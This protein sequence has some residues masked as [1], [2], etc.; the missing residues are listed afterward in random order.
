M[1]SK[2]FYVG[3]N[4]QNSSESMSKLDW[5]FGK[6]QQRPEHFIY[7][8]MFWS[9]QV[10]VYHSFQSFEGQ[11]GDIDRSR[12]HFGS[13]NGHVDVTASFRQTGHT[14]DRTLSILV[15]RRRRQL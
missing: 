3:S 6:K 1:S 4:A 15:G 13:R 9:R 14:F 11:T 10:L 7:G 2:R 12:M 8:S 5:A